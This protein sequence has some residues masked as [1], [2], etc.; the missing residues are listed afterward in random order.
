MSYDLQIWANREADQFQLQAATDAVASLALVFEDEPGRA[1]LSRGLKE[2]HLLSIDGP[3]R[4]DPEDVPEEVVQALASPSV[5]YELHATLSAS[6]DLAAVRSWSRG[7][8]DAIDGV[9]IDRQTGRL[10][11][12]KGRRSVPR[13]TRMQRVDVLELQWYWPSPGISATP[14]LQTCARHMPEATPHAFGEFEPLQHR[15]E[16]GRL[17]LETMWQTSDGL[18]FRCQ[19]PCLTGGVSRWTPD[20]PLAS[21]SLG[22]L[23]KPIAVSPALEDAL[24]SF[25]ISVAQHG[26]AFYAS[27][28]IE[29]A[30]LWNGRSVW[31]DA[32]TRSTDT[33]LVRGKWQGLPSSPARWEW[34]SSEHA[35]RAQ[36]R[37]RGLRPQQF[38]KGL[39]LEGDQSPI[40]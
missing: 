10:Y 26:D 40:R 7:L 29:R 3:L 23:A 19:L 8:T 22:L 16:S 28:E 6:T 14:Y 15:L 32:D 12:T 37:R 18:Y 35:D 34:H 4:V 2:R 9:V 20:A 5:L 11:P 1:R 24:R 33:R 21:L 25:F 31:S 13:P 30:W 17:T 38:E 39:F 36:H 27:L